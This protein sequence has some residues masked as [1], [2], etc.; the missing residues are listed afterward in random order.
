[1]LSNSQVKQRASSRF[2]RKGKMSAWGPG[3]EE[4]EAAARVRKRLKLSID[5]LLPE[6]ALEAGA[7]PPQDERTR[8]RTVKRK[9]Q[10]L[11]ANNS[12][13]MPHLRSPSPPLSTTRL[14]PILALPR[15]FTDIA[16]S[17]AMRHT[18]GDDGVEVGLIRTAGELLEGEKSLIQALGRLR[19]VLRVGQRELLDR[20]AAELLPPVRAQSEEEVEEMEVDV[21]LSAVAE[22]MANGDALPEQAADSTSSLAEVGPA[23]DEAVLALADPAAIQPEAEAKPNGQ[24]TEASAAIG[25]E[26]PAADANAEAGSVTA[27]APAADPIPGPSTEVA[28]SNDPPIPS[29]PVYIEN[30]N[31]FRVT[32]DLMTTFP[33]FA[34]NY[35]PATAPPAPPPAQITGSPVITSPPVLTPV[36]KLFVS[37]EGLVLTAAPP[38]GHPQWSYPTSHPGHPHVQR[39]HLD[40]AAQAKATDEAFERISELLADCSEYAERLEEARERVADVARARKRVWGVVRR[41]ADFE[42]LNAE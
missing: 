6:A 33:H 31:L 32:T 35:T 40:A 3:W 34:V 19:E 38:A 42:I 22:S 20:D 8:A 17:P 27:T 41:R 1:M 21:P 11:E 25:A 28:P 13:I 37:D 36:Q 9:R 24:V 14:A 18:L 12:L 39:Y 7:P 2:V 5:T 23:T 4:A 16:L 26:T 10:R 30:D 29:L 15:S